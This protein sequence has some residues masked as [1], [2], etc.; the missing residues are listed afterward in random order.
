MQMLS[1]PLEALHM[2]EQAETDDPVAL[3]GIARM[4][5]QIAFTALGDPAVFAAARG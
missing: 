1:E 5:M 2:R 4:A 3:A